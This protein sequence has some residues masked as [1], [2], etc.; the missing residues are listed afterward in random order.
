ML[1]DFDP[2]R[3]IR[4]L[5]QLKSLKFLDLPFPE[6]AQVMAGV[7]VGVIPLLAWYTEVPISQF[8]LEMPFSSALM[9][10]S[11]YCAI[12]VSCICCIWVQCIQRIEH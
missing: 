12:V 2:L 10:G 9:T 3:R 8:S 4:Y 11:L 7:M 5:D 1:P 6:M